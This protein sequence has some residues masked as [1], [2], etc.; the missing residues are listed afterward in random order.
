MNYIWNEPST[1]TFKI[2]VGA[3]N[4][5]ISDS[6]SV[7]GTKSVSLGA[8]PS[9]AVFQRFVDGGDGE[10]AQPEGSFGVIPIFF[11]YILGV[12][13]DTSTAKKT[14]VFTV[15]ESED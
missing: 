8:V 11:T 3:I 13:P 2:D 12:V 10:T 4:G 1:S 5:E 6:V 14:T 7:D 9:S 15:E